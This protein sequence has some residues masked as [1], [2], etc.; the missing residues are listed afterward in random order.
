MIGRIFF[1]ALAAALVLC[2]GVRA[3]D[4]RAAD[5]PPARRGLV[6]RSIDHPVVRGDSLVKIAARYG[7]STKVLA[8]QNGLDLHARLAVG[9][10]L[11]VELK[12]LLPAAK[13]RA[14]CR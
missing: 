9:Q 13:S 6:E 1:A 10:R 12:R 2:G 5:E 3:A 11:K 4:V 8:M 7:I 14:G